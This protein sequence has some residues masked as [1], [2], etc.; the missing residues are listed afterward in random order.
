MSIG[1]NLNNFNSS[2]GISRIPVVSP[3]EVK[4][5]DQARELESSKVQAVSAVKPE[6]TQ[7]NVNQA[8]RMANLE[9]VSLTFNKADTFDNI[10]IDADITNLDMTKAIS[11]M[12]RDSILSD[13]Q[14]FVGPSTEQLMAGLEDGVVIMK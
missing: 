8:S 6:V 10:G 13:Y 7:V 12:R 2:Y 4:A 11:D 14:Q 1:I 9:D 5:Q 3:E